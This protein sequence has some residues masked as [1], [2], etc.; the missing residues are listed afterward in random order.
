MASKK[1]QLRLKKNQKRIAKAV[2]RVEQQGIEIDVNLFPELPKSNKAVQ[3]IKKLLPRIKK[4]RTTS[5]RKTTQTSTSTNITIPRLKGKKPKSK[6]SLTSVM[7]IKKRIKT[8]NEKLK[9]RNKK[10]ILDE[11]EATIIPPEELKEPDEFPETPTIET[12]E[13]FDPYDMTGVD[14][15]SY[16]HAETYDTIEPETDDTIEPET[17][18]WLEDEEGN[19][20]NPQTGEMYKEDE[21]DYL[22]FDETIISAFRIDISHFPTTAEPMLSSWL[23]G[24]IQ[25]QGK[26]KVAIMLE[27][28]REAGYW[29]TYSIAYNTEAL[30]SL[31][32]DMM[33]FLPDLGTLEKETI[34]ESFEYSED[35]SEPR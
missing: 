32:S 34:V 28:G 31:M 22:P 16:Q 6:K 30:S 12:I 26:D 18:T 19:L 1:A 4:P 23:D 13:E 7:K 27:E 24:L 2:K 15:S 3:V 21:W 29:I 33:D 8:L 11:I 14:T 25:T 10:K 20:Y 5:T 9:T 17:D 35:W